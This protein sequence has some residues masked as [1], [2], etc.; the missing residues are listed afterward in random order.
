[1]RFLRQRG[2]HVSLASPSVWLCSR[3][4]VTC[5]HLNE[6]CVLI[7][8]WLFTF[9]LAHEFSILPTGEEMFVFGFLFASL[10]PLFVVAPV[11]PFCLFLC[12]PSLFLP[13]RDTYKQEM[14]QKVINWKTGCK[15]LLAVHEC[16]QSLPRKVSVLPCIQNLPRKRLRVMSCPLPKA[17]EYVY[18]YKKWAP[19]MI[20]S[21]HIC[22]TK[23]SLSPITRHKFK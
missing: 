2:M 13:G 11:V 12:P 21:S 18:F 3:L 4:M 23:L 9:L 10:L 6:A 5:D 16:I 1:M 14:W 19:V 15:N 7:V 20:R 22:F 8:V 17:G